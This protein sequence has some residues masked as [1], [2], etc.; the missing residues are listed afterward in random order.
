MFVNEAATIN[1]WELS[2]L[3]RVHASSTASCMQLDPSVGLLAGQVSPSA[4]HA[5]PGTDATLVRNGVNVFGPTAYAAPGHLE[6]IAASNEMAPE[7]TLAV[8]FDE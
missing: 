4:S 1:H 7:R 3:F 8:T 2:L 5:H 6:S